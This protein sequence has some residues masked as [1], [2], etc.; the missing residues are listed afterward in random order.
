[1]SRG[2]A[3]RGVLSF[4]AKEVTK[5]F[6]AVGTREWACIWMEAGGCDVTIRMV[7]KGVRG[8]GA[9]R[10]CRGWSVVH[11]GGKSVFRAAD[12]RLARGWVGCSRRMRGSWGS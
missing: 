9:W 3:L 2:R 10:K 11:V 5:Q 6:W 4:H 1:M 12:C 7:M 8:K